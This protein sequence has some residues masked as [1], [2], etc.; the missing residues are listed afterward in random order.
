MAV[1]TLVSIAVIRWFLV[2]RV[3]VLGIGGL[4]VLRLAFRAVVTSTRGEEKISPQPMLMA[5]QQNEVE[6]KP[7]IALRVTLGQAGVGFVPVT[8]TAHRTQEQQNQNQS[9]PLVQHSADAGSFS[10]AVV[11]STRGEDGIEEM[12]SSQSLP[13]TPLGTADATEDHVVASPQSALCSCSTAT[14]H[15]PTTAPSSKRRG[16]IKCWFNSWS[17]PPPSLLPRQNGEKRKTLVLDLDQTLIECLHLKCERACPPDFT[18]T[19]CEG[20]KANVWRRPHLMH[21]LQEAAQDFEVVLFTAAAQRHADAVLGV[22]DPD[23]RLIQHRL[24]GHH[25]VASPQWSWVKDLSRLGR[26]LS[27]T[28]IVDDCNMAALFQL[29]NWVSIPPFTHLHHAW[30]QDTAL[31]DVLRLLREKVLPATDVR[32]A[33]H[34]HRTQPEVQL[35]PQPRQEAA[36]SGTE[37]GLFVRGEQDHPEGGRSTRGSNPP[38]RGDSGGNDVQLLRDTSSCE[39]PEPAEMQRPRDLSCTLGSGSWACGSARGGAEANGGADYS[40]SESLRRVQTIRTCLSVV[41]TH[42]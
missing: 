18:Y 37:S 1:V 27:Q 34:E 3:V 11:V 22:L 8:T 41:T 6:P 26:D 15:T 14:P 19:D 29:E 7:R 25:T 39:S 17:H 35:Q 23:R 38:Q 32:Q 2:A 21:F 13:C 16:S 10:L 5:L 4:G 42:G 36:A 31:L 24:Y 12:E 28:L 40:D 9:Q 30:R 20:L 33:L